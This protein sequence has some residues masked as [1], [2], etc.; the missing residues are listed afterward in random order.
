M[1]LFDSEDEDGAAERR[2]KVK[3][4]EFAKMRKALMEDR[5]LGEM[6]E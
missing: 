6:G 1:D 2:R 4:R 5:E 3:Q